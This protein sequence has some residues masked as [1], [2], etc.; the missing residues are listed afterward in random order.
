MQEIIEEWKREEDPP[1]KRTP[2]ARVLTAYIIER[3]M[4]GA[5]EV[6]GVKPPHSQAEHDSFFRRYVHGHA[7]ALRAF[8]AALHEPT[9]W[10]R[11]H[12]GHELKWFLGEP[13]GA[14]RHYGFLQRNPEKFCVAILEREQ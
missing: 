7:G 4:A 6:W 2:S 12:V 14:A 13:G 5:W 11:H 1:A 8:R 3:A 10:D 9:P